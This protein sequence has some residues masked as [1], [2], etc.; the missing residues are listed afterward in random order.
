MFQARSRT[1]Q[2]SA[3]LGKSGP[4]LGLQVGKVGAHRV[5]TGGRGLPEVAY[6]A[7]NLGH[8]PVTGGREVPGSSGVLTSG[9]SLRGK[10]A[11]ASFQRGHAGF[12]VERLSHASS[13]P[14]SSPGGQNCV[15]VALVASR[16]KLS[17]DSCSGVTR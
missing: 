2:L 1:V 13:L 14:G 9:L 17:T 3:Y 12:K 5:E 15:R 16:M 4:H 7:A 6:L 11:H 8:V 10:F